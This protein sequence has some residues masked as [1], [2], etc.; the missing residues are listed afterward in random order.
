MRRWDNLDWESCK[1][2]CIKRCQVKRP[3][4]NKA[5][6]W[7]MAAECKRYFSKP[8]A[9][10][11]QTTNDPEYQLLSHFWSNRQVEICGYTNDQETQSQISKFYC[12]Q[13][14]KLQAPPKATPLERV[15]VTIIP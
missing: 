5:M 8:K 1:D 4:D 9:S 13:N 3:W 14:F 11:H 2:Q 6:Y 7:C 12:F 10:K 15:L